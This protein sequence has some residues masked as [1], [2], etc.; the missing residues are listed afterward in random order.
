[1]TSA[2]TGPGLP[3]ATPVAPAT[4]LWLANQ[5][6]DLVQIYAYS[7]GIAIRLHQNRRQPP[8][9]RPCAGHGLQTGEHGQGRS[10]PMKA[11]RGARATSRLGRT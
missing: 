2:T 5:L 1:M 7:G 4:G 8:R 11:L 10:P 9:H 6:R 3:P